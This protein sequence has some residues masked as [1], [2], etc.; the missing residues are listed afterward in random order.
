V[1]SVQLEAILHQQTTFLINSALLSPW[2]RDIPEKL[3]G[4]ELLKKFHAIYGTGRF[5]TAFRRACPYP[6]P[7]PSNKKLP[8][9]FSDS[10]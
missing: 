8:F 2:S 5:I 7:D 4:S 1:H 6:E 9:H 3:T 10:F